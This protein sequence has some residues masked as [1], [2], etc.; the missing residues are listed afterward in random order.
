M[1]N[2]FLKYP[3]VNHDDK[4]MLIFCSEEMLSRYSSATYI[5]MDGMYDVPNLYYQ[6]YTLHIRIENGAIMPVICAL[7]PG[8]SYEDYMNMFD[9]VER[10]LEGRGLSH[11]NPDYVSLDFEK[12]SIGVSRQIFPN[13]EY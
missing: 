9:A 4:S 1:V 12:A 8:K 10:L 5:A 11:P 2:P 3:P 13:A 7:L 6:L